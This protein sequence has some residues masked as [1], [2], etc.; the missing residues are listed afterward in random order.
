MFGDLGRTF[1]AQ[2]TSGQRSEDCEQTLEQYK[3]IDTSEIV[4]RVVVLDNLQDNI[5]P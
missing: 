1:S 2:T 3:L 5:C 4:I